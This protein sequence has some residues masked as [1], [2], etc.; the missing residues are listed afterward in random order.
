MSGM[1]WKKW[2]LICID[3]TSLGSFV[4]AWRKEIIQIYARSTVENSMLLG[5]RRP[6]PCARGHSPDSDADS[7]IQNT[8]QTKESHTFPSRKQNPSSD[9]NILACTGTSFLT[10]LPH[11]KKGQ[12]KLGKAIKRPAVYLFKTIFEINNN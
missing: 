9:K 11:V 1:W 6:L 10:H 8:N 4:T 2:I 7:S 12:L 5:C 3:K